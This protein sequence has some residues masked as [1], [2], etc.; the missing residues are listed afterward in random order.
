MTTVKMAL[1]PLFGL[2]AR[3]L[4]GLLLLGVPA[5]AQQR[6]T[7]R[8]SQ[9]LCATL[10][11]NMLLGQLRL[12]AEIGLGNTDLCAPLEAWWRWHLTGLQRF[13]S[14]AAPRAD[15]LFQ[16]MDV[17]FAIY[18]SR[19]GPEAVVHADSMRR[20][21][22]SETSELLYLT[23]VER[24]QLSKEPIDTLQWAVRVE[25]SGSASG[26]Y[27]FA[28]P[29]A[30]TVALPSPADGVRLRALAA[31]ASSARLEVVRAQFR[32]MLAAKQGFGRASTPLDLDVLLGPPKD[33]MLGWLGVHR[34]TQPFYAFLTFSPQ[35]L[36]SPI[37]ASGGLN[38]HEL[39]HLIPSGAPGPR[40]SFVAEEAFATAVGGAFGR[41]LA[42][43]ICDAFSETDSTRADLTV[44]TSTGRR[45]LLLL[46]RAMH[47]A[48][49][50]GADSMQFFADGRWLRPGA[51]WRD[52]GSFLGV[53]ADSLRDAAQRKIAAEVAR[54]ELKRQPTGIDPLR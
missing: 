24:T 37:T 52:L 44:Q 5:Q 46:A 50:S 11:P 6:D 19:L 12:S 31:H 16:H 41:S 30:P 14:G 35:S 25:R 45:A 29:I 38:P 39:G 40:R 20:E 36:I 9:A 54:C 43:E 28:V 49:R 4:L 10:T 48:L 15:S 34:A 17:A 7:S 32:D 3:V 53:P 13:A 26:D 22:D 8:A 21:K 2:S 18:R 51:E 27:T 42:S 1:G 23:A 47:D 33:T